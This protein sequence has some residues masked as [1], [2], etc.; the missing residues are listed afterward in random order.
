M[1]Q[2]IAKNI[3]S[4][5]FDLGGVLFDIDYTL[6]QKAFIELGATEFHKLYSLQKQTGLFDEFEKGKIP[7]AEFRKQLK[8][9]LPKGI[10]DADIDKAWNALLIGV[11]NAKIDLLKQLRNKYRVFLLSN[12]NEIHLAEVLNMLARLDNNKGITHLFEK[13]YYSCRM[14]MRKPDKEIFD[15]VIMDNSLNPLHTVFIDDLLHNVEGAKT[16][17]LNILHCTAEVKLEEYFR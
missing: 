10:T 11:P 17:G 5:I 14:G 13:T 2:K 6:T 15:K 16:A 8:E 4:V 1:S 7:P 3:T 12:T 9:K